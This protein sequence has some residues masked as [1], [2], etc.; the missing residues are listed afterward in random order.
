MVEPVADHE[1][2]YDSSDEVHGPPPVIYEQPKGLNG[3][4]M[5]PVTQV[6]LLGVVCFMGPGLFNAL[7]GLGAGGQVDSQTNSNANSA[8]YS[9]FAVM[10]FFA[11]SINNIL[12]PKLTLLIGSMGYSLYIGSYLA[13]NIHSNAGGFVVG[14]GAIL[15]L[16][17]GLLWTAQGSLMMA[18]PTESQKGKFIGIFWSIFNLG[19][20]VGAS[21][22]AGRN[23]KSTA[24]AVDNGTYIG[25]LILTLIGVLVPLLMA[26][27]NR[28]IRSDGTKVTTPRQPSWRTEFMGL[29]ITLKT[30]PMIVLL[31]PMFFTSNWFYTWQFS[32]FNG[33]LFSIR[34]RGLNNVCYWISQII[35]SVL[36]GLLLDRKSLSRRVRAFSGWTALFLMVFAVHIWGYF[37]QKEYS[38]ETVPPESNKMDI[39]DHGY[40]GRV[41]FYIC[42]GILDA[43]WQTTA[44]WLMGAMSNDPSKLAFFAGFYKSLQSAGAAGNWRADAVK[45]P[46]MNI[47]ISTWVLLVSGLVFALPM[48]IL[49]VKNHTDLDDEVLYV[50]RISLMCVSSLT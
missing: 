38:R 22:A 37:Y 27:P 34:A 25:F 46:Y 1:K 33:A 16:C 5:N 29:F 31:F 39:Y 8:L 24:N 3:F 35:G 28:M 26:N 14:A 9:T 43:M 6:A 12:G 40:A 4:Y 41:M 50:V 49:R 20:V 10:G 17:A 36:I 18:Y 47:F 15:G 30:D 42:C 45:V 23:W 21:V 48:L 32:G 44:Y 19:G 2:A 13:M 11:G 7:T